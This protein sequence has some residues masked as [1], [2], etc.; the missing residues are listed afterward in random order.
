MAAW[1]QSADPAKKIGS[2]LTTLTSVSE[3]LVQVTLARVEALQSALLLGTV[4]ASLIQS[5]IMS[6]T[7]ELSTVLASVSAEINN[8][9]SAL[10]GVSAPLPAALSCPVFEGGGRD[11]GRTAA[12]GPGPQDSAPRSLA[13]QRK[14]RASASAGSVR[15][16]QAGFSAA[17]SASAPPGCNRVGRRASDRISAPALH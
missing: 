13:S 9:A 8:T 3:F 16:R 14:V 2:I 4:E 10:G 11:L 15:S 6:A 5:E 17:H 7:S 1:S 12:L